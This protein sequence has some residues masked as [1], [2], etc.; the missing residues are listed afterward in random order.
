MSVFDGLPECVAGVVLVGAEG[1]AE[2]ANET[3]LRDATEQER[4]GFEAYCRQLVRNTDGD[5]AADAFSLGDFA[6]DGTGRPYWL[7]AVLDVP[8]VP[9]IALEKAREYT[10]CLRVHC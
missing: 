4:A 5:K 2:T 10:R 8:D 9:P 7:K 1:C 6:V 3:W